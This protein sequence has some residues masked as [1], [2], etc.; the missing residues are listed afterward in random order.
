MIP[1]LVSEGQ[2]IR[3]QR[4]KNNYHIQLRSRRYFANKTTLGVNYPPFPVKG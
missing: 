3:R 2:V 4:N 1:S